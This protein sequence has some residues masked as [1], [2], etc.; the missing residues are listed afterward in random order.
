MRGSEVSRRNPVPSSFGNETREGLK[1]IR[2]SVNQL[3]QNP[4]DKDRLFSNLVIVAGGDGMTPLYPDAN[5]SSPVEGLQNLGDQERLRVL[6]IANRKR[7]VIRNC[8]TCGEEEAEFWV[9]MSELVYRCDAPVGRGSGWGDPHLRTY[10]G[11]TYS[12]QR[13]GE[14]VLTK[15]VRPGFEIQVRQA[16]QNESVSMNS[17][18]AMDVW[19]D[20]VAVHSRYRGTPDWS[21]SSPLRINGEIVMMIRDEIQLPNG[22]KVEIQS[23][24]ELTVY[25]P[26]GEKALIR[27]VDQGPLSYVNVSPVAFT[28]KKYGDYLGLMGDANGNPSDDLRTPMGQSFVAAPPFYS[29]D[30]LSAGQGIDQRTLNLEE[31]YQKQ[32][33]WE[34]GDSWR[35]TQQTSL[36]EYAPG[37][38]TE[39]FTDLYFPRQ[40]LSLA[41]V[42]PNQI[43]E[44]RSTC[45]SAGV[46]G[47]ALRAC[48][49]DVVFTG[50]ANYAKETQLIHDEDRLTKLLAINQPIHTPPPVTLTEAEVRKEKKQI[51]KQI[52]SAPRPTA[53]VKARSNNRIITIV[54]RPETKPTVA[55]KSKTEYSPELYQPSNEPAYSIPEEATYESEQMA[56]SIQP[57]YQSVPE[58]AVRQK[59]RSAPVIKPSSKS[60]PATESRPSTKKQTLQMKRK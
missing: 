56:P 48:I 57:V 35:V 3:P 15:S 26:S 10:D 18:V 59:E 27:V 45:E 52:R 39:T 21:R 49:L 38:S 60:E 5:Y 6:E 4:T 32:L 31:T 7:Q 51:K 12:L 53:P 29:I 58:R 22:G 9:N 43:Q 34:F 16:P 46:G 55:E 37:N 2:Q 8:E 19:G 28:H 14:F 25:W 23:E 40:F 1:E 33:A 41:N 13:V 50:N 17:A 20:R 11:F 54:S 42:D 36:F 44:A 47:D 24:N 30:Q